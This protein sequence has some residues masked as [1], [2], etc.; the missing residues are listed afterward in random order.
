MLDDHTHSKTSR[1]RVIGGWLVNHSFQHPKGNVSE[2]TVFVP[3]RDHEWEIM[4]PI[5]D[6]QIERSNIAKDFMPPAA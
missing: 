6:P 5:V 3:D 4:P 1:V 2:S